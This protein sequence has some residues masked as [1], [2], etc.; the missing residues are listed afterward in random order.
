MHFGGDP[1]SSGSDTGSGNDPCAGDHVTGVPAAAGAARLR[2]APLRPTRP[3]PPPSHQL[4]PRCQLAA[5]LRVRRATWGR[6]AAA[7]ADP[8]PAHS[9]S[10]PQVRGGAR[11]GCLFQSSALFLSAPRRAQSSR[12]SCHWYGRGNTF[13]CLP[14]SCRPTGRAC[15]WRL[16]LPTEGH[17]PRVHLVPLG[18]PGFGSRAVASASTPGAATRVLG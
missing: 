13:P 18:L 1:S 9:L 14:I 15:Q 11:A 2:A 10:L 6:R 5:R 4:R 17:K 12:R 7:E 8:P 16:L 3:E